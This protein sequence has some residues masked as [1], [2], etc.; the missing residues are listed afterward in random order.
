M[1]FFRKTRR[2]GL[3][4]TCSH[5]LLTPHF[6]GTKFTVFRTKLSHSIRY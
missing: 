4:A 2:R 1:K 3:C 6:P 5:F